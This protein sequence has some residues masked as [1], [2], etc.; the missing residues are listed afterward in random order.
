[1]K[2][3]DVD[4]LHDLIQVSYSYLSP[5]ISFKCRSQVTLLVISSAGFGRRVSLMEA[6]KAEPPL[7]HKRTFRD[8]VTSTLEHMI[9]KVLFPDWLYDLSSRIYLPLITPYLKETRESFDALGLHML[10]VISL[11]RDWVAGGKTGSMDAAL[12]RNL[13]EA[14]MSND[15]GNR[16]LT[17]DELLSNTFV[18]VFL[19]SRK[20]ALFDSFLRFSYLRAMVTVL[21]STPTTS[22]HQATRNI[23]TFPLFCCSSFGALS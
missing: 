9:P 1:M 21:P 6:S 14:N 12:I 11:A 2:P 3:K 7:G 18:G 10:D 15:Q 22:T 5:I 8:A 13:V 4:I 16:H 20:E 23:Y 19:L 17:D